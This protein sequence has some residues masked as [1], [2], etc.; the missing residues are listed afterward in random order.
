MGPEP[1]GAP[2]EQQGLGWKSSFKS[3]KGADAIGSGI[4]GAWKP[5]PTKWDMGYLKVLF[6]YEWELLKSPAGA[7]IW[8]AK[9]VE[10]NLRT[11][12]NLKNA[13]TIVSDERSNQVIV[14]TFDNRMNEIERLI[15]AL[16]Q[17]QKRY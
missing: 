4:E 2:I 1:E 15:A 3:G 6:K 8:L 17:R 7:Y 16:D 10:E 12:L 11:R 9:D 13:G 5:N 14:Q